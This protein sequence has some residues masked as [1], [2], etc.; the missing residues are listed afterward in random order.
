MCYNVHVRVRN[1]GENSLNVVSCTFPHFSLKSI[2]TSMVMSHNLVVETHFMTQFEHSSSYVFLCAG[3]VLLPAI[4][5][6]R[7][8]RAVFVRRHKN[9]WPWG[10][11]AEWS[12]GK[13]ST[14][15]W[16]SDWGQRCA[17]TIGTAEPLRSH[18]HHVRAERLIPTV[19]CSPGEPLWT[20]DPANGRVFC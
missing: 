6:A 12:A 20:T 8:H 7:L 3:T 13:R 1:V 2:L 15:Q 19:D 9:R 11:S 4:S 17:F 5:T 18:P 16:G 10:V 14:P